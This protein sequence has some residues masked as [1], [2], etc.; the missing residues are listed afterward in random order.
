M[1][2]ISITDAAILSHLSKQLPS[3]KQRILLTSRLGAAAKRLA[4]KLDGNKKLG[5]ARAKAGK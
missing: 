2:T 5:V 4:P 3:K 1:T